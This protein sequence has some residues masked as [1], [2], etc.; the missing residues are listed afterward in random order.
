MVARIR[1]G[2]RQKRSRRR[3]EK[4]TLKTFFFSPV[5]L[6]YQELTTDSHRHY[7]VSSLNELLYHTCTQTQI[8][9]IYEQEYWKVTT[10]TIYL[11]ANMLLWLP[12]YSLFSCYFLDKKRMSA[13]RCSYINTT[14]FSSQL[15]GIFN[16]IL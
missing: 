16:I 2:K 1:S 8:Y 15:F 6:F 11:T 13:I 5:L 12:F 4:K 3:R 7:L 14:F 10:I 9:I